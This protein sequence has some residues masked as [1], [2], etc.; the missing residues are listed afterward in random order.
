MSGLGS[1]LCSAS[2]TLP[3]CEAQSGLLCCRGGG[4]PFRDV[5][6]SPRSSAGEDRQ[7]RQAWEAWARGGE[8]CGPR[9]KKEE[10]KPWRTCPRPCWAHAL[11]WVPLSEV[12][13]RAY[14]G[15]PAHSPRRCRELQGLNA[16][17]V[18]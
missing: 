2:I 4:C 10:S 6:K 11:A 9:S 16:K 8:A 3:G 7:R 15:G 18:A 5:E 1:R 13:G 14:A 12:Q 17:A